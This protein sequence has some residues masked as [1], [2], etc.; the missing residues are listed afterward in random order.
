MAIF[1]LLTFLLLVGAG[2]G[3]SATFGFAITNVTV[4]DVTGGPVQPG[5]TVVIRDGRIAGIEKTSA[6]AVAKNMRDVDGSGKFLIPGLWDTHVHLSWTT[7]SALPVLVAN[8]VTS[9]RDMGGLLPELDDWRTRIAA[10]LIAGPRIV[11]AGPIL[12]GQKFNKYEEREIGIPRHPPVDLQ[13]IHADLF[14][15]RRRQLSD[16]DQR[17]PARAHSRAID[18]RYH[19]T[20]RSGRTCPL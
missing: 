1:P 14:Q 16:V 10:G 7:G 8:G 9:V 4:I 19:T 5:M 2:G 18:P 13:E 20:G 15:G 12:N 17:H 3:P 6:G 11:R